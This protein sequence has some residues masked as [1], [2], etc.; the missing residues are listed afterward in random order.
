[1]TIGVK[2]RIMPALIS[3]S[4]Q[5]I[6]K[7]STKKLKKTPTMHPMIQFLLRCFL[8]SFCAF[9][10]SNTAK[11]GEE[12]NYTQARNTLE[13][14]VDSFS[15]SSQDAKILETELR[16]LKQTLIRL[17]KSSLFF[18]FI[19]LSSTGFPLSK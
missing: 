11:A 12:F 16:S 10:L 19:Q 7:K 2:R 14:L 13:N 4:F 18:L 1:M 3:L 8:I 9:S 17:E 5:E 6:L 15:I